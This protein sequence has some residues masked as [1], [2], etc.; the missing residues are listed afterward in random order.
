MRRTAA[1]IMVLGLATGL[2]GVADAAPG[3]GGAGPA[4]TG[5][6]PAPAAE[7]AAEPSRGQSTLVT[8]ITGDRV[9]VGGDG[10]TVMVEPVAGRE[11]V[12]FRTARLAGHTQLI[13]LDA[14]PLVDAGVLDRRLFDLTAL[15]ADGYADDRRD[16]VPLIVTYR[17]GARPSL[18]ALTVSRTLTS[19]NGVAAAVA[20]KDAASAW[21]RLLAERSGI[22]RVWLDGLR[23]P[24]LE[25]SVPQIGAPAAYDAG[26]TGTGSRVAVLDTGID[27]TH[28]DLAG[29]VTDMRNFTTE[30]DGD[31]VGHGTH[32][33]STIAGSGEVSGGLLHGVAYGATLLDGKVCEL[34]GCQESAIL[35]GM[36]WAAADEGVDVVNM[37]LG[38]PDTPDTDPLEAAVDRLTAEHGTLFVIAAGN[39]GPGPATVSSPGSADAALTVGAVDKQDRLAPFSGRGP[40]LD[41]AIKP[42]LTAPGVDI[43]AAAANFGSGDP[44]VTASGTSMA[45]PHV[46]GAAAILVE[47]HPDWSPDRLKA[48]L[49]ASAR[50]AAGVGV[51]DQGAGRVDVAR[52][53]TQSVVASPP[54]LSLGRALWPH[55]DDEPI[56]RTTTISNTAATTVTI[57]LRLDMTGPD[58]APAPAGMFTLGGGGVTGAVTLPPGG[59]ATIEIGADTTTA[60][61]DGQYA[62]RLVGTAAGSTV[63]TVP[64]AVDKEVESYN[65]TVSLRDRD[66]E[67]TGIGDTLIVGLDTQRE[68]VAFD[69]NGIATARLPRG[70]YALTSLIVSNLADPNVTVLVWPLLELT[71]D[72]AIDADARLGRPV[73][74]RVPETSAGL[75]L[76]LVEFMR[77]TSWG[78]FAAGLVVE[79]LA[80]VYTANVGGPVPPAELTSAI[81]TQWARPDGDG[82]FTDSPFV[83]GTMAIQ[84][85]SIFTGFGRVYRPA[86]LATVHSAVATQ[87]SG[88]LA[89]HGIAARPA[90]G[91]LGLGVLLQHP[92]PFTRSEH[93]STDG[94]RWSG[95]LLQIDPQTGPELQLESPP[96]EYRANRHYNQRWNR[97]VFGPAFPPQSIITDWVTRIGDTLLVAAPVTSDGA[98]HAGFAQAGTGRTALFRDGELVGETD[99]PGLGE[100]EVPPEPATYRLEVE[101]NRTGSD[102]STTV[103]TAWTFRSGHVD[104]ATITPVPVSAVRF[105]PPLDE[106]DSARQGRLFVIPIGYQSQPGIPAVIPSLGVEISYDDGRSWYPLRLIGPA[107]RPGTADVFDPG[108]LAL[109]RWIAVLRHASGFPYV[110]LRATATDGNGNR[111][112][113]TIIHAYR[114]R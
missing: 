30:D 112:E 78:E 70:R 56:R 17:D 102:L 88:R 19:V 96:V 63:I 29:R 15:V 79:D 20:K 58:G 69:P 1:L 51:F 13:P 24:T 54:S 43:L 59:S 82:G 36:E 39:S 99:L 47:Q 25:Q 11:H 57:A 98:G 103:R 111:V 61:P 74:I 33:A 38:G 22:E 65:L 21:P 76:A 49:I 31:V 44:Y 67:L 64:V 83:Y 77:V 2:G 110:S 92:M 66:G 5:P 10:T 113:Q 26:L 105:L 73:D 90:D 14:L 40:R 48:A 86:D 87:V 28:P 27:A 84:R 60:G 101:V 94:G 106:N 7:R 6:G 68:T 108:Q 62:G 41:G 114:L 52:L 50:P 42:D 12:R 34:F 71:A 97:A 100:F 35:A 46:A 37:S 81:S 72:T 32:V 75:V 18:S 95:L 80:D 104:D 89:E 107:A 45:T 16:S 109:V 23:R 85:G 4:G 9:R 8:L 3:R 93:L 91:L 55:G 53:I